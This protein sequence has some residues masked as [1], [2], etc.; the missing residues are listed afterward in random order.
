M[1]PIALSQSLDEL[2][3]ELRTSPEL[4]VSPIYAQRRHAWV[5]WQYLREY[6]KGVGCSEAVMAVA[7]LRSKRHKDMTRSLQVE[8]LMAEKAAAAMR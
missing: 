2:P 1:I 5:S 7:L 3:E 8:A 6:A 4:P